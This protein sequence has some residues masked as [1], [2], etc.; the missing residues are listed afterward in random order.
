MTIGLPKLAAALSRP[1][2]ATR[3]LSSQGQSLLGEV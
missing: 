1:V 3:R 2:A